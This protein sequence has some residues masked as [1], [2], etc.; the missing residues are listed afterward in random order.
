MVGREVAL[1]VDRAAT[2]QSRCVC[3]AKDLTV[4]NE[5]GMPGCFDVFLSVHSGE[6]VDEYS[7]HAQGP[8]VLAGT[9]SGGNMQKVVAACELSDGPL[10]LL[11]SQPTRGVDLSA[12]QFIWRSITDARERARRYCCHRPICRT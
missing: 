5:H 10:L 6:I 11:V 9:L 2:D 3:R 7:I 12:T 1:R 4:M 8:L